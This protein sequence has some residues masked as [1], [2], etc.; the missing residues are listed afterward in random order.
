M[1]IAARIVEVC[2]QVPNRIAVSAF[3]GALSYGDLADLSRRIAIGLRARGLSPGDH[4]GVVDSGS[5]KDMAAVLGLWM[6]DCVFVPLSAAVSPER[7]AHVLKATGYRFI[8]GSEV[9]LPSLM[10]ALPD[11]AD[12]PE[13]M[14][15]EELSMSEPSASLAMPEGD[16]RA[17]IFFTSGSQGQ[18][19]GVVGR[20]AALAA[21]VDWHCG[22]F[23]VTSDRCFSQVAPLPFD[24]SLKE[25][26]VPL[27][28]GAQL[29][30]LPPDM[31]G[32][33][34]VLSEWISDH[35][36]TDWCTLPTHLRGIALLL[37]S[38]PA[39]R[40][41]F[42]TVQHTLISGEPLYWADVR[43]WRDAVG[44]GHHLYNLYGPTESTVLKFCY[45]IQQDD[46]SDGSVPVGQPIPG[47]EITLRDTDQDGAGEV[48]LSG[49]DLAEGYIG[50]DRG[51]F[52]V[53]P[54][55]DGDLRTY[56][57]GDY[58][59]FTESGDLLLMGRK[60]RQVKLRGVRVSLGAVE[61]KF[62][63][64]P[65]VTEVAA[66]CV[67]EEFHD[68]LVLFYESTSASVFSEEIRAF[69]RQMLPKE[70][71]PSRIIPMAT[72]LHSSNGKVDLAALE[73]L[74]LAGL[75]P[76][77]SVK[78]PILLKDQLSL[79][80]ADVLS[81]PGIKPD[82]NFFDMGGDSISAIK[83]LSSLRHD[84]GP[85]LTLKDIF[86]HPSAEQLAERLAEIRALET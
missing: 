25:Y 82:D 76:E 43:A 17:Y 26:L 56:A 52:G 46:G 61:E 34:E 64:H 79:R 68:R 6:A 83:L 19:K 67:K 51:G 42:E 85:G 13:T 62:R 1:R 47:T 39:M 7:T 37:S 28:V 75:E 81:V 9:I 8:L 22:Q 40:D 23:D 50:K 11:D 55:P 4:V 32:N 49:P 73:R 35:G 33:A 70:A 24:F 29:T 78:K 2:E 54:S 3:D 27:S 5:C 18:P 77:S 31:R 12:V 71:M 84:I 72:M 16:G 30:R 59:R 20:H 58:G 69:G 74:A 38:N 48:V 80:I 44:A 53:E 45:P 66:I 36:V 10:D 21:Y 14:T 57:T 63:Q 60:D 15:L 41:R 86:F 65:A